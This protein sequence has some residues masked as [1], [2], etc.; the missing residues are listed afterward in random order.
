M[1]RVKSYRSLRVYRLSFD[2]AMEIFHKTKSYPSEELYSLTIQIRKSSR[3]VSA[4][5]SEA[6][7]S[8]R[9]PNLFVH[10]L[11]ISER[12]ACE[13]QNW[14]DFSVECGYLNKADYD[15][16]T[17]RYDKVIGMLISM[18]NKPR[19]WKI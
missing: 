15:H 4:N 17:Q 1:P 11:N 6:F 14:L 12:E 2:L 16:L 18:M 8:R 9:Y 5:I 7:H 13:T 10:K 3:S 19:Q